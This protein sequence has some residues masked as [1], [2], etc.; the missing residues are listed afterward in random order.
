MSTEIAASELRAWLYD[1]GELA[2]LDVREPGQIA[3]GHILFSAPLPYSRFELDLPR[4]VPNPN[5]RMVL[6][7]ARRRRWRQR[8][9]GPRPGDRL[10]PR[11]LPRRR[12]RGMGRAP[13]TR[14]TRA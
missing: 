9:A 5:V 3:D 7:D 10:C 8:A 2:L 13:A 12:R 6:C 1:D 11:L 4:L 14:S